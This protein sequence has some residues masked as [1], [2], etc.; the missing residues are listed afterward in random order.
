M[1]HCLLQR[2][3]NKKKLTKTFV[4]TGDYW[5]GESVT[6]CYSPFDKRNKKNPNRAQY[7]YISLWGMDDFGMIKTEATEK[8]WHNLLYLCRNGRTP[9]IEKLKELG[10]E[11]D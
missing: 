8:D 10:Y 7:G 3:K 11:M 5:E 9:T 4:G 1:K 6:V 2:I